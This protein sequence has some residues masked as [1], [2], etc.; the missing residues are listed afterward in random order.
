MSI[1][2]LLE[3]PSQTALTTTILGILTAQGLSTADMI[4]VGRIIIYFGEALVT[5]GALQSALEAAES[6][7][8]MQKISP[9]SEQKTVTTAN[10][11]DTKTIIDNV[12]M[13]IQQLQQQ[14]QQ[15]QE[16]ILVL[17]KKCW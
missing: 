1:S 16:Q 8:A 5:I 17:Q 9:T 10:N 2:N 4:V 12:L 6:E 13:V 11:D 15:L 7:E 3:N 14:N